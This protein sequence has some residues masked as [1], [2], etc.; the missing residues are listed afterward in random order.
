MS[1]Y[2]PQQFLLCDMIPVLSWCDGFISNT[3]GIM[4]CFLNG[5]NP[6]A[7]RVLAL[8]HSFGKFFM[9]VT[10]CIQI[11]S[12]S[13]YH[14]KEQTQTKQKQNFIRPRQQTG[15]RKLMFLWFFLPDMYSI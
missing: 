12:V 5:Q 10:L 2:Q 6:R 3:G 7:E 13:F 9:R 14:K 1:Y 11:F 4:V 8:L 15:C